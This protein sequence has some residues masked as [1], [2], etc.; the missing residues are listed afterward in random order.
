MSIPIAGR[1]AGIEMYAAFHASRKN[2]AQVFFQQC[3]Q[4]AAS[5]RSRTATPSHATTDACI[6][7][8]SLVHDLNASGSTPR[9]EQRNGRPYLERKTANTTTQTPIT[10]ERTLDV[11]DGEADA[12]ATIARHL[13]G[14]DDHVVAGKH[15]NQPDNRVRTSRETKAGAISDDVPKTAREQSRLARKMRRIE[16]GT[17]NRDSQLHLQQDPGQV[18]SVLAKLDALKTS[19]PSVWAGF[20]NNSTPVQPRKPLRPLSEL[21]LKQEAAKPTQPEPKP[22]KEPWQIQKRVAEQK[23][24]ETG[25]QPRK[26]LSPDTLE[27]IRALHA[28]DSATYTTEMLSAHFKITPEAIRR[29]LK[30]KWQ[31]NDEESEDRRA[32]WERRGAKK[33]QSMAEQGMRAPAKWRAMGVGGEEGLKEERLPRRRKSK[34][35]DGL[36]WDDVVGGLP[37]HV[38]ER[39]RNDSLADR[40]L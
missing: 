24:G 25:W 22:K 5:K 26:R 18:E 33:W 8:D 23:F 40:L 17:H 15:T 2:R 1:M 38:E 39:S 10:V 9:N 28:S 21:P 16:A 12:A 37:E 31:P 35:E 20:E 11:E 7:P 6:P 30:S 14:K 19:E 34:G 27:G 4:F 13:D 3:R 32:R 29:I 36:S